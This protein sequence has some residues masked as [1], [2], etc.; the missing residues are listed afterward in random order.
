M[1]ST[2]AS[3]R[4]A[5]WPLR[6]RP[7]HCPTSRP[8]SP[9][10]TWTP[11]SLARGVDEG[12]RLRDLA[13]DRELTLAVC[14]NLLFH[15]GVQR[16]VEL[17]AQGVLGRPT[18]V[19]AWN[20]GW[21]DLAPWDFRRSAEQTGG[22]AWFDG[23]GH[24]LYTI[25]ALLGRFRALSVLHGEGPSR[26]GGE[27]AC[28]AAGLLDDGTAATLRVSYADRLSGHAQA[29]PAG[30]QLGFDLRGT[31]GSIRVD[32][33]PEAKVSWY[34]GER[35]HD[36]RVDASFATAFDLA[37]RDFVEAVAARRPPRV[38]ADD[39]LHVLALLRGADG[40]RP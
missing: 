18:T 36:E 1:W 2:P 31:G 22:G 8:R 12:A 7:P 38:D 23:G 17:V 33:L 32:V 14:H 11:S 27:D 16:A 6:S 24:L 28:A 25:E 3:T 40:G 35:G 26:I 34:D 19:D 37:A 10:P 13:H 21:L 4:R 30:W 20:C 9:T 29:W 15:P 39:A 5:S